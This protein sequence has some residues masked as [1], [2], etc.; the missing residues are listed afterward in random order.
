[1]RIWKDFLNFRI[2]GNEG[3]VNERG[4]GVQGPNENCLGFF[5]NLKKNESKFLS[6]FSV[7]LINEV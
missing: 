5:L 4:G 6:R 7:Y 1:M 3:R 2:L